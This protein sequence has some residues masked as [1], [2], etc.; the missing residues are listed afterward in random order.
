MNFRLGRRN[1]FKCG[2]DDFQEFFLEGVC[3]SKESS[4]LKSVATRPRRPSTRHDSLLFLVL[5]LAACLLPPGARCADAAK[6]SFDLPADTADASLKRFSIQS[7]SEVLFAS[8]L[9]RGVRTNPVYETCSAREAIDRMLART[10]LVAV[11]D[12]GADAFSVKRDSS[13]QNR[14]APRPLA[15]KKSKTDTVSNTRTMSRKNLFSRLAAAAFVLLSPN[16]KAAENTGTIEGRVFNSRSGAV[17]ENARISVEGTDQVAFTN[18]DGVFHLDNIPAGNVRLRIFYTGYPPQFEALSV[19]SGQ[20]TRREITLGE[21]A[22]TLAGA[23]APVI[24]LDAFTVSESREMEASAIAINEQRFASNI[25][26]VVSTDEFGAIAEGNVGEFLRF[27]PGLLIDYNGVDARSVSIDGAPEQNTP[28]TL[29]GVNLPAS[30]RTGRQVEVAMF[31]LN[32]ISRIEVSLSPTPDSPGS[33]LAGS[34]NLVPRSSFERTRPV[35]NVSAFATMRDNLLTLGKQP[36]QYGNYGRVI[37]PGFDASWLVPVNS[38]FGFS[39]ALGQSTKYTAQTGNTNTW[40][41]LSAATNGAAFPHTTPENAYL[42]AYQVRVAPSVIT[43]SSMGLTLDFKLSDRDRLSY[44][45]QFAGYDSWTGNRN[46]QFNPTRIVAGSFSPTTVQGVAGAGDVTATSTTGRLRETRTHMSTLNWRHDGPIWKLDAGLGRAFTKDALRSMDKGMFQTIVARVR[47]V[48]IGFDQITDERPGTITVIDNASKAAVNPYVLDNYSLISV[49]DTPLRS[50]DINFTAFVNARR[51]FDWKVPV[52]LRAG[53]DFRQ[54]IREY[55]TGTLTW[56]Y[57]GAAVTGSAKPFVESTS[58]VRQTPYGFPAIQFVD[59]KT[60]FS[61]FEANPSQF[62]LN[63]NN[64]YRSF[65]EGSKH[66]RE[67]VSSAYVRADAAFLDRRLNIVGGV[68]FE[69]TNVEAE[70]PLTDLS[71]NVRR[72]AAGNPILDSAGRP[73]PIATDALSISKLT[74]LERAALSSKEYLR[75]FP[76]V[77]ASYNL[78]ENLIARAAFSTSIGRPDFDQY[79]GGI[80]LPNTDNIPSSSN[81]IQVNNAGIKPWMAT[82]YRIRLEYYF[83]GVGQLSV[84]AY[85]RDYKNFFGETVIPATP[86]FLALYSLDPAVYGE[87]DVSTQYNIPGSVKSTGWEINYKQSLTFLPQWA[88]GVQV[89]G[90]ISFRKVQTPDMISR[91]FYDIPHSGSWGVSLTRPRFNVRANVNFRAAQRTG[92]VT[93]TGIAEGTFN[94][95][96]SRTTIDLLGEY[97]LTK[98]LFLFASLRDIEDTSDMGITISPNAPLRVRSILNFGSLWTFGLKG[99][100]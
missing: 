85:R 1:A 88:R 71:R 70:G 90:N 75:M 87:Y 93:G 27:L 100:F 40:R 21:G 74:L 56:S 30:N 68:R 39:V 73:V 33:A 24:K 4:V 6:I 20:T 31:N 52:S 32:N 43:R 86:E 8:H 97:R 51:D 28:V 67:A 84:G 89:F 62:T 45:F 22:S 14:E 12:P 72:D 64:A 9:V 77:N 11:H 26:Q 2:N 38:R 49:A 46:L 96:P 47:N 29:A 59:Y 16:A 58:L 65:V 44:A 81:T 99:T 13:L 5:L 55:R 41:G 17:A 34:I 82:S 25:K 18:P 10:G 23:T 61:Y 80:S 15:T 7:G 36:Y 76:S 92:R 57:S 98:N 78:R 91:G 54:T 95:V 50:S 37:K 94:Y 60:T 53:L 42:S 83:K 63:E 48:T 66:A 79:A 69:Q 35:L 19:V 3:N